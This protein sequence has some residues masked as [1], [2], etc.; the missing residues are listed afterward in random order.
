MLE[1]LFYILKEFGFHAEFINIIS[2]FYKGA[3]AQIIFN[4]NKIGNCKVNRGTRQG[5]PLSPLRFACF[6]EHLGIVN[7]SISCSTSPIPGMSNIKLYA[8]DIASFLKP[9][10]E[11]QNQIF[12]IFHHYQQIGRY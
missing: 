9:D 10:L 8:D 1:S 2:T 3:L 7:H 5:C 4:G 6:I 12:Y 11:V